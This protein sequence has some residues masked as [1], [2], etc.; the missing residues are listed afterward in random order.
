MCCLLL[1]KKT[2]RTILLFLTIG[3]NL[4]WAPP[5]SRA[6]TPA[7]A[8]AAFEALIQVYWDP[9]VQL[10]RKNEEGTQ[11]ADFWFAAQIWDTVMDQYDRTR[12]ED[13]KRLIT[14]VYDGFIREHP[15]WTTN[16]YNDDIM[17]WPSPV[18]GPMQSQKTSVI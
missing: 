13:V 3:L 6:V 4:G 15:D 7:E 14:A 5:D 10:F 18:R 16:K 17:W 8:D 1:P 9:G 11:K 2:A 12:R